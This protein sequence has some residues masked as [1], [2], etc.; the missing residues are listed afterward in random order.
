MLRRKYTVFPNKTMSAIAQIPIV[1]GLN[2][3]GFKKVSWHFEPE[4]EQQ[5]QASH[6]AN[7]QPILRI[8]TF[9]LAV[10]FALYVWRDYHDTGSLNVALSTATPFLFFTSVFALLRVPIFERYW[11]SFILIGGISSAV[12]ALHSQASFMSMIHPPSALNEDTFGTASLFFGQQ[13]RFFMICLAL[14]HL[15]FKWSI[16]LNVLLLCIGFGEFTIEIM[17]G[18][19]SS[20]QIGRFLQFTIPVGLAMVLGAWV[21]ERLSRSAFQANY[22]LA[23]LQEEEHCKRVE[24]EGMLRVLSQS[25]GSIVHDLGNPLTS[26]QS[27]VQ[28]LDY[29]LS[30][31]DFDDRETLRE[32]AQ[33]ANQGSEML[34]Y[35]RLSLME[36]TR[37]L[38][39]QPAV[40][41]AKPVGVKNIVELGARFQKPFISANRK[42]VF[43]VSEECLICADQMKL[44]TVFMNLIGN[45]LKYSDQQIQ[46][47]W[48]RVEEK[49]M[50]LVA[51]CDQ[52]TK[53]V[54]LTETNA[55]KLFT[56][57]RRLEAHKAIDG[58]GLGLMS[59]K[60]IVSAHGGEVWIEGYAD[61]TP[62][63]PH[64]STGCSDYPPSLIEGFLTAFVVSCP[65]AD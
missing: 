39:G 24:T 55:K 32:L 45:S 6:Y 52:G 22:R 44:T 36:Q 59:I 9:C 21:E 25:I 41:E 46:V 54:G 15:P 27:G 50:L 18:L 26:V 38:E 10:L 35:L 60:N 30:R 57:F 31:D 29:L 43:D 49:K 3:N 42:P 33:V 63:S 58:T 5:F 4:L 34:D 61:G 2:S 53:G 7:I 65:L 8:T 1:T 28:T 16:V 48:Q 14:M 64:F 56:P 20:E 12:I 62:D 37:V 40:V 47:R 11:K 51:V 19:M 23:Q 17:G 13:I